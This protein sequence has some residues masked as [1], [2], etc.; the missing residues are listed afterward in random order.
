MAIAVSFFCW[1]PMPEVAFT[2]TLPTLFLTESFTLTVVALVLT[3]RRTQV[4]AQVINQLLVTGDRSGSGIAAMIVAS[5]FSLVGGMSA[6]LTAIA[7]SLACWLKMPVAAFTPTLPT[8]PLT[9]LPRVV[10]DGSGI[11]HRSGSAV[12]ACQRARP[13]CPLLTF[14]SNT[15][16]T[17]MSCL[18]LSSL[19]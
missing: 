1:L 19:V 2:P 14:G 18:M 6:W 16:L 11:V 4:D 10:V 15:K 9:L 8:L 7:T 3:I 12:F 13:A 5:R 17:S